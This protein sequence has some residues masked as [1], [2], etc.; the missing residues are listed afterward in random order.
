MSAYIDVHCHLTGGEYGDVGALVRSLEDAGIGKV[1]SAGFDIPSSEGG[2]ELAEKY[3]MVY[4][5]A[6][7]HPTELKKYRDGDLYRIL[8][9]IKKYNGLLL[10]HC[11]NGEILDERRAELGETGPSDISNHPL[12]RPNEVEHDAGETEE[13]T[14]ASEA[15]LEPTEE[16][17]VSEDKH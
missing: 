7:F 5:T 4:F 12:S 13:T 6:G 1:I 9:L 8:K 10:I 16:A 2:A 3:T 11:E 15:A 17:P 14:E